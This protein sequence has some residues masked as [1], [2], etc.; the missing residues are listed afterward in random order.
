MYCDPQ[1]TESFSYDKS[2][3]YPRMLADP[4]FEIPICEGSEHHLKELPKI[5]KCGIYRCQI[6]C[7]KDDYRKLFA[8]SINSAYTHYSL[9]TDLKCSDE[10]DV[11]I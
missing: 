10:Y 5:L 3:Y 11:S 7:D 1:E 2:S 4:N 6:I 8:F 9:K